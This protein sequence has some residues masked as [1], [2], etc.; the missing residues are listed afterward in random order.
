MNPAA[1]K[2]AKRFSISE[3]DAE[4]LVAAGL[5]NPRKLYDADDKV[6]DAIVGAGVR[7]DVRK[8]KVDKKVK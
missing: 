4:K 2:L 8:R 1:S 6:L 5:S 3:K 7:A